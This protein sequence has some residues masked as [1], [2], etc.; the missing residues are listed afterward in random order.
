MLLTS[1]VRGAA[2]LLAATLPL[3]MAQAA[4]P[5][6]FERAR[7]L[8]TVLDNPILQQR[9]RGVPVEGLEVTAPDTYRVW[10]GDCEVAVNVVDDVP[11]VEIDPRTGAP[12]PAM[13]GPRRFVLR[14]GDL[15]C[16][17]AGSAVKP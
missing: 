7:E 1:G 2:L 6:Y 5:P 8:T 16:G 13:V 9:L 10:A 4:L 15:R 3:F 17:R 12:R 14:I 11:P